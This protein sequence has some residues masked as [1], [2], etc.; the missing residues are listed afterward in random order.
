MHAPDFSACSL[1]SACRVTGLSPTQDWT[2]GTHVIDHRL[3]LEPKA[4]VTL[5]GLEYSLESNSEDL[6]A[7]V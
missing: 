3:G 2:G 1:G 6:R 4:Y 7:G 5:A